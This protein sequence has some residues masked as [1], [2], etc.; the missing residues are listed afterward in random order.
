MEEDLTDPV[1]AQHVRNEVVRNDGLPAP[2]VAE[3][4]ENTNHSG[5]ADVRHNNALA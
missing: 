5:N 2:E 1:V 4:D 3:V